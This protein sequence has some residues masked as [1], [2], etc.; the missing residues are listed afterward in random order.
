MFGK[1]AAIS[2]RIKE[3]KKDYDINTKSIILYHVLHGS[4]ISILSLRKGHSYRG[5]KFGSRGEVF[6]QRTK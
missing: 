5:L 4:E 3:K 2:R 1:S 6:S